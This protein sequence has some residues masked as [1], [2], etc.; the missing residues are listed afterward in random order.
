MKPMLREQFING[1]WEY[2]SIATGDVWL[3]DKA[4]LNPKLLLSRRCR[5]ASATREYECRG[6]GNTKRGDSWCDKCKRAMKKLSRNPQPQ[7][8]SEQDKFDR[9]MRERSRKHGKRSYRYGK[10]LSTNMAAP[11]IQRLRKGSNQARP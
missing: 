10:S 8:F 5:K 6:C 3:G 2:V 7:A 11:F 4:S 9:M 1:A